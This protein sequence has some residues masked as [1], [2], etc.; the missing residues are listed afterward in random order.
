MSAENLVA[1]YLAAVRTV[2][3]TGAATD[4]RSYYAAV[5]ALLS[6]IG[7]L[8]TPKRGVLSEPAAIDGGFPD[9]ALFELASQVLVLPAEIKPAHVDLDQLLASVQPKGYASSFGGGMVLLSNL[10]EFSLAQL[11]PSTDRLVELDRCTLVA[12]ESDLDI[13][14]PPL[15]DTGISLVGLI[16]TGCATTHSTLREPRVVARL[17][18]WHASRLSAAIEATSDPARLLA[19]INEAFSDGLEIE[20]DEEFLVPTIV[21][22]LTY[23]ILAA[24]LQS[25]ATDTF[26]WRSAAYRLDVPLFAEILHACLRPALVRECDLFPRLDALAR[27]LQ[28]VDRDEFAAQFGGQ[29]IEYFY[30][31]FLAA[32]DPLLRDKLGVW[33]TPRA[34]ADYQVA[35]VDHA[36][37]TDLGIA[38]GIADDSVIVLDPASGTGTYLAATLAAIHQRHLDNGQPAE[39]ASARTRQAATERILGFE[40]LPAAFIV[41]HLNIGRR[42]AELGAPL[43][44]NDRLRIYLT[45]SLTGWDPNF[46][47]PTLTLFPD[48]VGEIEAARKVKQ[49]EPVLVVL[50]NPPYQGYSSA[51]S[52]EERDMIQPWITPLWPEWGIRKHRL[53]DLYV[54]FWKAAIHRIVDLTDRGVVSFISN[55]KWLGG[56]SYPTMREAVVMGF[57][58]IVVDDL[59]GDYNNSPSGGADQSVFTTGTATGIRVGTAVVTSIRDGSSGDDLPN[60]QTRDVYGTAAAKRAQLTS[61]ATTG[62]IDEDLRPRVVSREQRWKLSGDEGGDYPALDEYF[63]YFLSGVQT[64]RDEAVVDRS[65]TALEARMKRYFDSAVPWSTVASEYPG[66]AVVRARYV[67]DK[68]RA[69]LLDGS[70]FH[71]ERVVRHLFK[72]FDA[73]WMYW[74]PQHKLLNEARVELMPYFIGLDDQWAIVAPQTRDRDGAA[75]GIATRAVPSFKSAFQDA[76]VFPLRAPGGSSGHL[77]GE[78][79]FDVDVTSNVAP[80]WIEAARKAGVAGTDEVIGETVFFALLGIMASD[81]WL[82]EQAV[83]DD[84]FPEIPLPADRD[85]LVR[86]SEVGQRYAALC[87]TD[88]D[89]VGVTSGSLDPNLASLAVPDVVA[90][91]TALAFGSVGNAGGRRSGADV[92]WDADHGWRNVPDELWDFSVCGF[93]PLPKW[94]SYYVGDELTVADRE[95]FTKLA[96]RIAAIKA[97]ATE[98]DAVFAAAVKAPLDTAG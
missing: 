72:P 38:D 6:G 59:H 17:L 73:R 37:R 81:A 91:T 51:E 25:P 30:E 97:L 93:R 64:I 18:A 84:D 44:G 23:G 9:V 32:F 43:G 58:K 52:T 45:N 80:V 78:L 36:L 82:N 85:A 39:L 94:L 79:G 12:Q 35:R 48:L 1:T 66:F 54:R 26:D 34:I 31:P 41:S 7:G 55:R 40:I 92:L 14:G 46:N 4:E 75:R 24:W 63:T 15:V 68:V 65:K 28:W 74:E 49:T 83:E 5:N 50:G 47:P 96:R 95:A 89:V 2:R 22:T 19:P 42:V 90:G 87:E 16:E 21:Q 61:W 53:N 10:R 20:L 69:R 33:Y 60:V 13:A 27:V 57:D 98:A 77:P 76:R 88:V 71:P 67:G 62:S 70:V 11:D 86:A 29:A 56:R 3:A 8:L